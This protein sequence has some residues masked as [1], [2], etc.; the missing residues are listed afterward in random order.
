M[1]LQQPVFPTYL[2]HSQGGNMAAQHT[3]YVRVTNRTYWHLLVRPRK[4]E[5]LVRWTQLW[6]VADECFFRA[7]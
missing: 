6:D 5:L 1:K 4:Y 2:E 7:H 3:E